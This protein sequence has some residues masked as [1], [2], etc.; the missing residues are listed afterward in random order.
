M[1][2]GRRV[3]FLKIPMYFVVV[4]MCI[5]MPVV[6]FELYKEG[7]HHS[8]LKLTCHSYLRLSTKSDIELWICQF[9]GS[10]NIEKDM[11]LSDERQ[12]IA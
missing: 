1:R 9:F 2:R 4:Q 6:Y 8:L 10:S 3:G 12:K 7:P 5:S 11:K